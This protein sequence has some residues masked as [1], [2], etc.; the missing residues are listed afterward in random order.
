MYYQRASQKK[1][2]RKKKKK[3]C[4]SAVPLCFPLTLNHSQAQ[5]I[6]MYRTPYSQTHAAG[7]SLQMNAPLDIILIK[8]Q[9]IFSS[10]CLQ[11]CIKRVIHQSLSLYSPPR[12]P[13]A[14]PLQIE[15]GDFRG[16][17]GG[18]SWRWL[19]VKSRKLKI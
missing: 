9:S 15:R 14:P 16:R 5:I 4:K 17:R 18:G 1:V 2:K 10:F 3:S 8:V 6:H 13:A 19:Y 11:Q 12:P 7:P